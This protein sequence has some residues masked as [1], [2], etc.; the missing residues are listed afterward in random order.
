MGRCK[1]PQDSYD[2]AYTKAR[3]N[4]KSRLDAGEKGHSAARRTRIANRFRGC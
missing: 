3:E 2:R 4:G 1:N